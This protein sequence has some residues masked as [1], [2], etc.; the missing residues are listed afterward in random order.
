MG[1]CP[2]SVWVLPGFSGVF[3]MAENEHVRGKNRAKSVEVGR[4]LRSTAAG[5]ELR[6]EARLRCSFNLPANAPPHREK[7]AF[8]W[9]L[10]GRWPLRVHRSGSRGRL[11]PMKK[12]R[13]IPEEAILTQGFFGSLPPPTPVGGRKPVA[14]EKSVVHSARCALFRTCAAGRH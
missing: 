3:Y 10:K 13:N 11:S 7:P 4:L 5:R 1:C 2:Y 8:A 12:H 14:A 6:L 9:D